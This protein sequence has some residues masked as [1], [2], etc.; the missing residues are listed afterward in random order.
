MHRSYPKVMNF[1][2]LIPLFLSIYIKKGSLNI[3][4]F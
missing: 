1:Q 3:K 2:G 4:H